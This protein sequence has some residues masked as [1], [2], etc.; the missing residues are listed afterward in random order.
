M[1]VFIWL[2]I[3]GFLI[4]RD[5]Y[6]M[7]MLAGMVLWVILTQLEKKKNTLKFYCF[8]FKGNKKAETDTVPSYKDQTCYTCFPRGTLW[9]SRHLNRS[10]KRTRGPWFDGLGPDS[11]VRGFSCYSDLSVTALSRLCPDVEGAAAGKVWP[12]V[13]RLR[14]R[15]SLSW[16]ILPRKPDPTAISE[17]D[18]FLKLWVSELFCMTAIQ[19]CL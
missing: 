17:D 11:A 7:K 13:A 16:L 19:D 1:S 15:C 18:F 5:N 4:S 12:R 14:K 10:R 9:P 8:M 3:K 6:V 2:L